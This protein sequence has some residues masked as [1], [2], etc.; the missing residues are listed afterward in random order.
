MRPALARDTLP[1]GNDGSGGG[2]ETPKEEEVG[3]IKG[4]QARDEGQ[5]VFGHRLAETLDRLAF[6]SRGRVERG[7]RPPNLPQPVRTS[8]ASL[9]HEE[10]LGLLHRG[11]PPQNHHS[12][13]RGSGYYSYTPH[14]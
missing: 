1:P 5:S 12:G 3:P 13:G 14:K 6:C 8:E 4:G 9:T 2:V 11:S 10:S 7:W